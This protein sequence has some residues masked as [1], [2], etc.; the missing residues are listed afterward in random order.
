MFSVINCQFIK[1]IPVERMICITASTISGTISTYV[2]SFP[3]T[4]VFFL[5]IQIERAAEIELNNQL[6]FAR[7]LSMSL[8]N[9]QENPTLENFILAVI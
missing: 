4:S 8:S 7:R 3:Q 5:H 2:I 1:K 9:G 6:L